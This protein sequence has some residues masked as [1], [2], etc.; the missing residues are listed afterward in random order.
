MQVYGRQFRRH[1]S[2]GCFNGR[3]T[4]ICFFYS[5]DIPMHDTISY[6]LFSSYG[7]L[8]T[9][10]VCFHF[11]VHHHSGCIH[12]TNS[13]LIGLFQNMTLNNLGCRY[14]TRRG[15]PT[16]NKLVKLLIEFFI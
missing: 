1:E 2:N 5:Q 14:V 8:H 10:Q 12:F 3:K 13:S 7:D 16:G 15:E 4:K 6:S 11:L 9:F